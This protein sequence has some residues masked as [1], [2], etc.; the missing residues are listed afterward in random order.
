[1][2]PCPS[3]MVAGE[4]NHLENKRTWPNTPQ[5]QTSVESKITNCAQS[6]DFLLHF[7]SAV[8]NISSSSCISWAP[9]N[10]SM[11]S[12]I[13]ASQLP[14]FLQAGDLLPSIGHLLFSLLH[15]IPHQAVPLAGTLRDN[16]DALLNLKIPWLHSCL[17]PPPTQPQ[18]AVGDRACTL[19]CLTVLVKPK[20]TFMDRAEISTQCGWQTA[21]VVTRLCPEWGNLQR[22]P[23]QFSLA[24]S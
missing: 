21:W 24:T 3:F 12:A 9:R 14:S 20:H 5:I 17:F 23:F 18:S 19:L 16:Y 8:Q 1:M 6:L 10:P 4:T 22:N 15:I 13:W 7:R 2:P 11:V